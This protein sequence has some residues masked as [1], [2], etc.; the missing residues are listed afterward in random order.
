VSFVVAWIAPIFVDGYTQ[1]FG[2]FSVIIKTW[3][4]LIFKKICEGDHFLGR[5]A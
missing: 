5:G 1:K 4:E 3:M 2:K